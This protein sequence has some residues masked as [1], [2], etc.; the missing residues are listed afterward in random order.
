VGIG[1]LLSAAPVMFALQVALDSPVAGALG[2]VL[3]ATPGYAIAE[4][5]GPRPLRWPERLLVVLGATLAITVLVGIVAALAPVGLHARTVALLEVGI[6]AFISIAWLRRVVRR[7]TGSVFRPAGS[8]IG[9]RTLLLVA[10]GA[11]FASTGVVIATASAENQP[12]PGV[13]QF[14]AL[15]ARPTVGASVGIANLSE[16]PLECGVTIDRPDRGALAW[17]PGTVAPGETVLGLLPEAERDETAPWRL[18][19]ECTGGADGLIERQ[20][21]IDPPR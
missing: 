19:L 4:T 21:S 7:E 5:I 12:H 8:G 15:P 3:L 13:V 17:N 1:L 10:L 11:T 9:V 18:A 6:L 16:A 2:L 20:V 14:W